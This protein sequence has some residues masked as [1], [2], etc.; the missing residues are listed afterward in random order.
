MTP[1][2]VTP[3]TIVARGI[4]LGA[5]IGA[6]PAGIGAILCLMAS[7]VFLTGGQQ[8]TA[9]ALLVAAAYAVLGSMAV[10][11]T[12]GT[13]TGLTL[14][15]APRRLLARPL[16]RGLL[17][18]VTAALPVALLAIATLTG[19]GYTLASY[20]PSIHVLTWSA[21]LTIALVAATRSGDITGYGAER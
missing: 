15:L 20:P 18:G 1:P 9:R 3:R 8:G 19:D 5:L 10:G 2:V 16:L 17:A 21:T 6:W 11:L 13:A 4:R 7:F 12:L 14:A